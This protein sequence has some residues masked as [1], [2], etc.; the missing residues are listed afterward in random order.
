MAKQVLECSFCGR[1]KPETNLLIAGINAH[2]CD[3]CIEQAHGIV[4]EELKSGGNA[5]KSSS[6][7]IL[8]K[9]KEIRAFLDQYVIGQDQTKKVMSVAVYNHYKRLM[10]LQHEEDVEIEKSNIIMVGQTGTG[11]TLV[12]KTIARMLEVPLAIVDA[13]VLTEAGYVGEDVESILTRLLQAADYD[14]AKAERGIVFIDEIDKIARKSDNPSITRD[15]SGE[16]VQQALLKL[17]EGTVVNVPPKG[18]RKHPDQKFIEVN[19]KDILFIAGGAFDGI[20]RIISKR[21]NRTAV[22]Y[23]TSRNADNIDKDNLLQ[24]IIPKDIKDFGLIPEIIGRLPVLTHMDP[25]DR[26]TLRAIL[27]EPKNALIKQYKKLFA[28][29]EVKFTIDDNALDYIVDKALEYKLG[30]RGLRSL[31]EAILTDAMYDLPSSD[32]KELHVD[33]DYTRD[34]LTKNLLKRLELAS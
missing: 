13:T 19:T 17:L 31:C 12:A 24:Y 8:K 23:S 2:V 10:Q 32:E 26:A 30:A 27:T 33:V 4:L 11:K 29:D 16:G 18:G 1:K 20:E 9:P 5:S 14:L 22:G 25:L 15:V 28:M 3:R 34:A 7:L 6:D 21:L